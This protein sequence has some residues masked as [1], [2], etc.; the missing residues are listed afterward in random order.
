MLERTIEEREGI[1]PAAR[2]LAEAGE[3]LAL[4]LLEVEPGYEQAVAAALAWRAAAVIATDPKRGARAAGE[5]APRRSGRAGG[6]ARRCGRA[7]RQDAAVRRRPSARGVR[8]TATSGRASSCEG[9]WLAELEQLP[10]ARSGVVVSREGHGYDADRGELWFAGSAAEAL[11]L[12]LE[13]RRRE[14]AA[15]VKRLFG[16]AATAEKAL[17]A[18]ER[19][20]EGGRQGAGRGR[21]GPAPPSSSRP[22]FLRAPRR[23]ERAPG[24]G[25]AGR[26]S[27]PPP[28]CVS[29]SRARSKRAAGRSR[30]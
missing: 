6:R 9:I 20:A 2:A 21:A 19:E 12:E 27:S 13:A 30:S 23:G 18:A 3:L 16:E 8:H 7:R 10:E 14:L 1:P 26:P 24:R 17:D 4:S 25:A 11:L 22:L 5:G 15:E 28:L 29:R